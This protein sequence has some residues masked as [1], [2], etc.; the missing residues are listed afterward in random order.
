MKNFLV[1]LLFL[2]F[3]L[4]GG[5]I[6]AVIAGDMFDN[7]KPGAV[8]V[9]ASRGGIVNEADL[10]EALKAGKLRAAACDAFVTEPPTKESTSLYELDNFIGTPHIGACAEE[11][12]WRMGT[13]VANEI[14]NIVINGAEPAHR[15][16]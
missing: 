12:L 1:F 2:F 13:E 10:Y 4:L 15:V 9:N 6:S 7:F 11:A 5:K 14:I 3:P 8:L 16:A